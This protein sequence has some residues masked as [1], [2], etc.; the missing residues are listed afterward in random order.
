MYYSRHLSGSTIFFR[1]VMGLVADTIGARRGMA[2]CLLVTTLPILGMM[3]VQDATGFIV[4]RG[5]IGISLAS[6]VACQALPC[7]PSRL[8]QP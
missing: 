2:A 5:L 8:I 1:L 4:C 3:Y 7:L 6:F